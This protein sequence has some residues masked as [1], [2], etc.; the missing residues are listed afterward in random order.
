MLVLPNGSDCD[1]IAGLVFF[2]KGQTYFCLGSYCFTDNSGIYFPVIRNRLYAL[3]HPGDLGGGIL[4]ECS[5]KQ[6]A[7]TNDQSNGTPA[8]S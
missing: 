5:G 1:I 4:S 2:I 7:K 6:A 8:W 3:A